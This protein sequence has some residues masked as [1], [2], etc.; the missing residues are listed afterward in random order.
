M[1]SHTKTPPSHA[2]TPL[3][4]PPH[5]PLQSGG[6][7]RGTMIE[8]PGPGRPP[9]VAPSVRKSAGLAVLL[10]AL[11]G[12]LGLC[13]LHVTGGLVATVAVVAVLGFLG[14]GFLPLLLLWPLCVVLA[15]CASRLRLDF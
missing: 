11:F 1:E 4:Y 10:A 8:L 2:S 12:P 6:W 9:L 7:Y 3:A 15:A 5:P 14:M 13:Y